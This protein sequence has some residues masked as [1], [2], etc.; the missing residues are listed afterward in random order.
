MRQVRFE[1]QAVSLLE[2]VGLVIHFICDVPLKIIHKFT[3]GVDDRCS[4]AVCLGVEGDNEELS[5]QMKHACSEVLHLPMG[6]TGVRS[7]ST[8]LMNHFPVF[9]VG[10]EKGCNG[11]L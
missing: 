8:A 11:N 7:F 4:S 1:H 2:C 9:F 10:F 6:K 5:L 3:V